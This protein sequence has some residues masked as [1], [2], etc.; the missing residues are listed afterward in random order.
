MNISFKKMITVAKH[1][2]ISQLSSIYY[3]GIIL[4]PLMLM[5]TAIKYVNVKIKLYQIDTNHIWAVIIPI[6]SLL[7]CI[8]YSGMTANSI[9]KDKTSK[10]SELLLSIV[11]AKEQ[12]L[13]KM[14]AIYFLV[15][16]NISIYIIFMSVYVKLSKNSF[17]QLMFSSSSIGFSLYSI[18]SII[19]SLFMALAITMSFACYITDSTQVSISTIPTLLL[20]SSISFISVCLYL[21][22]EL[23]SMIYIIYL[24]CIFPPVGSMLTPVLI[25]SKNMSYISGYIFLIIQ[26]IFM[27]FLFIKSINSYKTGLFSTK[28]K[29]IFLEGFSIK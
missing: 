22:N 20:M 13:G 26:S 21:P 7:L 8:F 23:D 1:E 25:A 18:L 15:L 11:D 12:I 2:I 29:N 27:I 24:M 16:F 4:F 14:S 5:V 9:A 3:W 19:A 6:T 28:K 17:L 10:I